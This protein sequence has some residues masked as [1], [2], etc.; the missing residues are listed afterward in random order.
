MDDMIFPFEI[1]PQ[2]DNQFVLRMARMMDPDSVA[3]EVQRDA[4]LLPLGACYWNVAHVV[5]ERGGALVL[6]WSITWWPRLF[7]SSNASCS[8]EV[9]RWRSFRCDRAAAIDK[10]LFVVDERAD[11]RLDIPPGID[12]IHLTIRNTPAVRRYLDA[13]RRHQVVRR[14]LNQ[15]HFRAGY[16][17]EAMFAAAAGRRYRPPQLMPLSTGCT[18]L[19]IWLS[20]HSGARVEMA[21]Q[22]RLLRHYPPTS[23]F[24]LLRPAGHLTD[25]RLG[26]R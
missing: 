7:I 21:I 18:T 19:R 24:P 1:T 11:I 22:S 16:W 25:F 23:E 26:S 17:C 4:T 15:I 14:E 5:Q 13:Y 20:Q 2:I 12:N 8:L 3:I 6:G 10:A 9:P